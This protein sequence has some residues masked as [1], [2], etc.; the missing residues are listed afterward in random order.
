LERGL[1]AFIE[2]RA[3]VE[4]QAVVALDLRGA[5]GAAIAFQAFLRPGRAVGAAEE[6]DFLVAQ[7]QQV[8]GDERAAL[9]VVRFDVVEMAQKGARLPRITVGMRRCARSS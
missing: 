6:G 5:Q 3:G 8:R 1:S 2:G 7:L 9:Q 4:Q